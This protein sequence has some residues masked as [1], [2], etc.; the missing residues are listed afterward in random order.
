MASE[1]VRLRRVYE[2]PSPDD[3]TRVLVDRIWPRGLRKDSAHFDEW[4]KHVAPSKDLRAWYGHEPEKFT[5]FRHRYLAEL[6]D[7]EQSEAMEQLKE[8][9]RRGPVTVLTATKDIEHSHA[10]VL[11]ALLRDGA[12]G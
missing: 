3:G 6:R 7:P 9:R 8:I 10:A 1:M 12:K 11:A 2:D 5:E 4:L